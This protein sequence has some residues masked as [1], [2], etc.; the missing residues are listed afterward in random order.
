MVFVNINYEVRINT[1]SQFERIDI[2][3]CETILFTASVVR[4]KSS[5]KG[6]TVLTFREPSCPWE[7]YTMITLAGQ[8]NASKP[9][10]GFG[11][12]S[13]NPVSAAGFSRASQTGRVHLRNRRL[14]LF[15]KTSRAKP[16][17]VGG[18]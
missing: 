9:G 3:Q 8:G 17:Q 5:C 1:T 12:V 6:L 15:A 13:V 7:R 16:R 18:K 2:L 10:P 11:G 4:R 14:E